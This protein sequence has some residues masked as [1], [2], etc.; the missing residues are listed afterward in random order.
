MIRVGTRGSRLAV[1]QTNGV[2]RQLASA[3]P[4]VR[5]EPI[6][7]RTSGDR[8]KTVRE[9]RA[10]GKG[11][12]TREIERALLKKKIDLAVHS[13]KDLPTDMTAGVTIG[14]ILEREDPADAFVG[15]TITRLEHLPAGA[16]VGTASLRRQAFLHA[17]HPKLKPV[18]L[19]GNL[20]TRLEKI[21]RPRG[22]LAGIIVAAA[23]LKRIESGNGNP[24]QVLST[25]TFVPSAGQG[26]LAIECREGDEK[27]RELLAPV[28][29]LETARCVGLERLIQH[30][31]EGGCQVPMGILAES[32]EE[33]LLRV[34]VCIASLDGVDLIREV[35]VGSVEDPGGLT[36]AMMILLETKGGPELLR[37][38]PRRKPGKKTGSGR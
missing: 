9:L 33:D 14:A 35:A 20:D 29:H 11:V 2:I 6:V 26:A 7:I 18:N 37:S 4:G 36:E 23:G 8:I 32:P 25:E 15:R 31:L 21:A 24:V 30:R 12:F 38:L 17:F 27:R 5:F 3:N 34:T 13:A 16:E 19:R 1:A 28:H 10:A 22:K